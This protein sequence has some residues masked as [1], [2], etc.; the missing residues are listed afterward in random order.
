MLKAVGLASGGGGRGGPKPAGGRT[1]STGVIQILGRPSGA[2]L[3]LAGPRGAW[4]RHAAPCV[5]ASGAVSAPLCLSLS[6]SLSPGC[7]ALRLRAGRHTNTLA[8]FETAR[9]ATS[10]HRPAIVFSRNTGPRPAGWESSGLCALWPRSA[11]R[12]VSLLPARMSDLGSRFDG[13]V[14]LTAGRKGVTGVRQPRLQ[15][16][17]RALQAPL[18]PPG[19]QARPDFWRHPHPYGAGT[20]QPAQP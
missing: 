15:H 16:R 3:G 18:E 20:A 2:R 10:R 9:H 5:V 12:G 14:S 17:L 4:T 7:F 8:T 11:R 19:P 1:Q 13:S 6:L